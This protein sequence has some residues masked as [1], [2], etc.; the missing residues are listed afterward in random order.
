MG[1]VRPDMTEKI[2]SG[3]FKPEHKQSLMGLP[4]IA[5]HFA[6]IDG[7]SSDI[8]HI[9]ISCIFTFCLNK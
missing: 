4:G 2:L 7:I 6:C 1:F 5:C 8:L 9:N 3:T